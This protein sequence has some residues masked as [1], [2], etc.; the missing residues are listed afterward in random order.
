MTSVK[1]IL[2]LMLG[3]LFSGSVRAQLL[4]DGPYIE[5]GIRW[6]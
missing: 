6:T 2:A 1:I 4:D 5:F 3:G